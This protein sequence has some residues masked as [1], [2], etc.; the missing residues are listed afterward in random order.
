VAG[1]QGLSHSHI[2]PHADGRQASKSDIQEVEK[3]GG[4][5]KNHLARLVT[6]F[7]FACLLLV[8]A[9]LAQDK[10]KTHVE[11]PTI[12]ARLEDVSSPE[13][14]VKADYESISGGVGVPRQWARDLALYDPN[15]RYISVYR[16]PKTGQLTPWT[17]TQQEY[18][19]EA[20]AHLV[21]VGFIER[22]LAHKTYRFGNIATVLSSFEGREQSTGKVLYRGV[23]I[24][25]LYFD[26]KRWWISSSAC[27]GE[28]NINPIPPELLPKDQRATRASNAR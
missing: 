20:D 2:D 4:S 16:E 9:T 5:M 28:H 26:G 15:A 8:P 11:I 25:Q 18:V 13:A 24:Y 22:E 1:H 27:D 23:N 19:D 3:N 6:I 17:P 10:P 12:A 7:A 14:I 21:S